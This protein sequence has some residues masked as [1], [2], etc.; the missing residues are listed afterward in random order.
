MYCSVA[1]RGQVTV[2][3]KG[4][5]VRTVLLPASVWNEICKHRCDADASARVSI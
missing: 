5:K 1:S 4:G 2:L 3:G